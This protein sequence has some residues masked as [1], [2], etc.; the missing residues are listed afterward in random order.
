MLVKL[1]TKLYM[2]QPIGVGERKVLTTLSAN[3]GMTPGDR[4]M[5]IDKQAQSQWVIKENEDAQ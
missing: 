5:T 1:A 2:G 4:K 3:F